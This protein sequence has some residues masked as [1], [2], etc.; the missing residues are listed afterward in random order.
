MCSYKDIKVDLEKSN[1]DLSELT[2]RLEDL[3]KLKEEYTSKINTVEKDNECRL[4]DE[5][6]FQKDKFIES[7][8]A[9]Y[10]AKINQCMDI[11]VRVNEKYH[12]DMVKIESTDYYKMMDNLDLDKLQESY[13]EIQKGISEC[14][15]EELRAKLE[16]LTKIDNNNPE[17]IMDSLIIK[18]K[19]FNK[20]FSDKSLV[21]KLLYSLSSAP[22]DKNTMYIYCVICVMVFGVTIWLYP[23]LIFIVAVSCIYNYK[24]ADF[25]IKCSTVCADF[26]YQ[27]DHIRRAL[28]R[29]VEN[30]KNF[31]KKKLLDNFNE[32]NAKL[33]ELIT[34]LES[35]RDIKIDEAMKSFKPDLDAVNRVNND[36]IASTRDLLS[37]TNKD[38][39]EVSIQINTLRD[40]ISDLKV[41]LQNSVDS[42][43]DSYMP[44]ELQNKVDLPEEILLDV[45]N[46]NPSFF[47]LIKGPVLFIYKDFDK[48]NE[49]INLLFY[50]VL[51]NTLPSNFKFTF[52]DL[53][54]L[55]MR[56]MKYCDNKDNP[57]LDP[58]VRIIDNAKDISSLID[59][60]NIEIKRRAS[61]IGGYGTIDEYNKF[62]I[63]QDCPTETYNLFIYKNPILT[64]LL[65]DSNIYL[66][67]NGGLTGFYEYIFVNEK[68]L[69]GKEKS[70]A[71]ELL[72]EKYKLEVYYI[73]DDVKKRSRMFVED[74][75]NNNSKK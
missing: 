66:M 59:N 21:D 46:N 7:V 69:V 20:K 16:K 56:M 71:L 44:K 11:K 1:R 37:T 42:L 32:S 36:T 9:P 70:A 19:I 30:K 5:V 52:I 68:D 51:L 10:K 67:R 39:S 50:Q 38:I 18:S 63:S 49:F 29:R 28:D 40:K 53:E 65:T 33:S 3:L 2:C 41:S 6:K 24:K 72:D 4:N 62:M 47:P 15:G 14:Y 74:F 12:A 35:E 23:I 43:I 13:K 64:Q 60:T 61:L 73:S 25:F 8:V 17:D 54:T 45:R 58:P 26:K 57:D 75:I 55:D 48:L 27:L 31:D 22:D 34:Q